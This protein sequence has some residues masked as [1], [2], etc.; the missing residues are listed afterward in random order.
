MSNFELLSESNFQDVEVLSEAD[1]SGKKSWY[2]EGVFLQSDVVNRNKRMYPDHI[3]EK[4]INRYIDEYVNT[5]RAVGELSHPPTP[6]I[7]LDNVS[8]II[9]SINKNNTNYIGKAK[10]LNTPSGRIAEGLLEGG[11]KLG[12]SSRGLGSVKQN[13]NGIN[14]VQDNFKL[15]TVDIVYQ[16]SAPDA[17]VDGLMENASF[18]W[19]T[20]EEDKEYLESI[21]EHVHKTNRMHLEERKMQVFEDFLNRI[22]SRN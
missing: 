5:K 6:E 20:T 3:M 8:H 22:K 7:N 4:E 21:K 13:S 14:E 2:L 1:A 19:N 15:A 9:E 10:I 11:V 17:F 18:V 12:V 16:P